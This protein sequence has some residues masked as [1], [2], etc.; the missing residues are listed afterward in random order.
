MPF[1]EKKEEDREREGGKGNETTLLVCARGEGP[2]GND[3][4][5]AAA[6]EAMLGEKVVHSRGRGTEPNRRGTFFVSPRR[7]LLHIG[8][9]LHTHANRPRVC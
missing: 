3:R 7:G 8:Q 4:T 5:I 1:T 9:G 2:G 6:N